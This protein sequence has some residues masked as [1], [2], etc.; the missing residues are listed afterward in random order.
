MTHLQYLHWWNYPITMLSWMSH[1]LF[2]RAVETI[3]LHQSTF[4]MQLFFK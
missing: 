4:S 1:Y 3:E 2:V